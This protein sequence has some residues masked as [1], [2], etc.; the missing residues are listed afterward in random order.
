MTTS[1]LTR[2]G[3]EA[4]ASTAASVLQSIGGIPVSDALESVS[5]WLDQIADLVMLCAVQ[6]SDA[7][8]QQNLMFLAARNAELCKTVV[9][10]CISQQGGAK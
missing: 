4:G 5:D 1:H 6:L 7:G 8:Q 2:P 10:A 3:I 9:D